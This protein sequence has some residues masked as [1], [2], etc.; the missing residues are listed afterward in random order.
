MG[1]LTVVFSSPPIASG[2]L[3]PLRSSPQVVG[4]DP[5]FFHHTCGFRACPAF[6]G[7]GGYPSVQTQNGCPI[8]NVGHDGVE[9]GFPIKD[10]GN[11][12]HGDGNGYPIYDFGNDGAG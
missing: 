11:D 1:I 7:R 12:A 6:I 5:S 4:G 8:N 2:D 9:D 3:S 10:V